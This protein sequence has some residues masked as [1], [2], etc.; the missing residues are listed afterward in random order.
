MLEE[1]EIIEHLRRKVTPADFQDRSL[2]R[3]VSRI[4]ELFDE[5]RK[6]DARC[7]MHQCADPSSANLICELAACEGPVVTDRHK[8]LNDCI[9]RLKEDAKKLRQQEIAQQIKLAQI[10]KNENRLREL[11][12]EFQSLSKKGA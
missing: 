10:D 11:L 7:L 3:I 6:I 1:D 9:S 5:G 12:E 4:F 8:L 2:G